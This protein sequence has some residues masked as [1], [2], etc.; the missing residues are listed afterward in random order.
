MMS[1]DLQTYQTMRI[2]PNSY[3]DQNDTYYPSSDEAVLERLK[4]AAQAQ[5]MGD[6]LHDD[7]EVNDFLEDIGMQVNVDLADDSRGHYG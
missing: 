7:E 2:S 5:G 3:S 1:K 4:M 6:T